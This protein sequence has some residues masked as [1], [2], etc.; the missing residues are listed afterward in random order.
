MKYFIE[1]I[2]DPSGH[3]SHARFLNLF[4]GVCACLFCWKLVLT[5]GMSENYFGLL[6]LYGAGQ[7]TINKALDLFTGRF[8]NADSPN[9]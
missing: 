7:Q 4:I 5:G 1:L 8:K 6:L 2:Q 3:I 9:P